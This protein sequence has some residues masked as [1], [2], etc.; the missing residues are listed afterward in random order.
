M[1]VHAIGCIL[2]LFC[3]SESWHRKIALMIK[4][5]LNL[6]IFLSTWRDTSD[7]LKCGSMQ[8]LWTM[9]ILPV[10][11]S[12]EQPQ[13]GETGCSLAKPRIK[14]SE[15][16]IQTVHTWGLLGRTVSSRYEWEAQAWGLT[17][18]EMRNDTRSTEELDTTTNK[19]C[20]HQPF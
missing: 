15:S 18:E 13:F 12:T 20:F 9:N 5:N 14:P 19:P 8:I 1:L 6:C 7:I 16:W 4:H 17:G 10:V 11:R 3:H 2:F